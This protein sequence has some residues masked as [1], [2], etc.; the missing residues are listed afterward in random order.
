[1]KHPVDQAVARIERYLAALDVR[2]KFAAIR[3][4]RARTDDERERCVATLTN[5]G[6]Q[7]ENSAFLLNA[8]KAVRHRPEL[9]SVGTQRRMLKKLLPARRLDE[10]KRA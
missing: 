10:R 7:R 2:A 1:M 6:Q 3:Y 8:L 5:I 4:S 9:A